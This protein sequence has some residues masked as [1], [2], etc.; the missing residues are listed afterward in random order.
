MT[1]TITS[2]A[3][4]TSR[5]ATRPGRF[6]RTHLPGHDGDVTPVSPQA[7]RNLATIRREDVLRLVGAALAAVGTTT[8]LFTQVLS[9]QGALG[10]VVVAYLLFLLFFV[11]LISFDDD[12]VTIAD[13][14]VGVV[15][16]S[17]AVVLLL[18]L[19]VVVVFTIARGA[20][21]F[22]HV[23]FWTQDLSMAG[24]LDPL[25]MGGRRTPRWARS[26]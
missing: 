5:R 4:R 16:H 25:S 2:D 11:V 10:F 9:A 26:S 18:A 23:N 8:W 12:R 7:R 6:T 15:I 13:R 3:P 19:A 21:A 14:V 17:A 24:P 22:L 1:A 20:E